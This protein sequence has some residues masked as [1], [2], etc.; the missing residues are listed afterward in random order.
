V[1]EITLQT[2]INDTL[3]RRHRVLEKWGRDAHSF[4]AEVDS[5]AAASLATEQPTTTKGDPV[6]TAIATLR[7]VPDKLRKIAADLTSSTQVL[8]K[9]TRAQS[10]LDA[11]NNKEKGAGSLD[12]VLGYI[13]EAVQLLQRLETQ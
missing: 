3:E 2:L 12:D 5:S 4:I 13:N 7:Q 8:E 6:F 9:L 10:E 11:Y 1:N